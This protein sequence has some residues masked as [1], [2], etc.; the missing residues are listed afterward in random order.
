MNILEIL[1]EDYA[2]FPMNQTYTLYADGVHFKDPLTQFYGIERYKDMIA[3]MSNWFQEI[4]MDLHSIEQE[5]VLIET[6]WTLSW[7]SPLPWRPAIAISG[8]S[9]LTL[10]PE[11]KIASHYDYWDISPWDVLKQH[12]LPKPTHRQ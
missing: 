9:E 6:R 3:F 4:K 12:F 1:Q 11:G 7:R 5:Y 10:N 2:R 8:R